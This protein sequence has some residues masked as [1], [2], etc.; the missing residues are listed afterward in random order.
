MLLRIARL[1]SAILASAS[2]RV[3]KYTDTY[4][5]EIQQRFL[6]GAERAVTLIRPSGSTISFIANLF[7]WLAIASVTYFL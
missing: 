4:L 5:D 7:H 2:H 6:D 3:L 1:L